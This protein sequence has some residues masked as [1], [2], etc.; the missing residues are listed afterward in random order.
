MRIKESM[1]SSSAIA[2][3]DKGSHHSDLGSL[4]LPA[5][6]GSL[7]MTL[8]ATACATPGPVDTPEPP[9]ELLS[10]VQIVLAT[11]TKFETEPEWAPSGAKDSEDQPTSDSID[12]APPNPEVEP[13]QAVTAKPEME[14]QSETDRHTESQARESPELLGDELEVVAEAPEARTEQLSG[15][16]RFLRDGREQAFASTLLNQ[17]VVAW[18]PDQDMPVE[19]MP[20][21][22]IVTRQRRFFPQTMV[23][24]SGTPVRFPN[25]DPID[26]NVYSLTPE[27]RFDVGRYGKG[28]GRINV[29]TGSGMVE[30]LCN[31]HPRMAAFLLVLETPYFQTPGDDGFFDFDDLPAGKGQIMVWNYRAEEPVQLHSLNLTSVT[32]D[33]ELTINITHP[34]STQGRR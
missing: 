25:M 15:R 9:N 6:F 19:A 22:Q 17:T 16:I 11:P 27:H 3:M 30:L 10:P 32:D 18:I 26:H 28:E 7:V 24:T 21:R 31:L 13:E 2:T 5:V 14:P 1:K 29:F 33:V 20:E 4:R 12:Q 23:V 8:I 34:A